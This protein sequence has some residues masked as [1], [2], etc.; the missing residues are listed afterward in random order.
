[1][2]RFIVAGTENK[3]KDNLKKYFEDHRNLRDDEE[4][5]FN[6]PK[7]REGQSAEWEKKDS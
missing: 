1:M 7:W 4:L 5:E 6:W 3:W 2:G